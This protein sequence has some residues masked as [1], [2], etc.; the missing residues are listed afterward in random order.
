MANKSTVLRIPEE[1]LQKV[2]TQADL[3]RR[4]RNS[5]L[6]ELIIDGLTANEQF[7]LFDGEKSK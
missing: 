2:Q 5:M 4:S 6:V 1:I 7:E 3:K